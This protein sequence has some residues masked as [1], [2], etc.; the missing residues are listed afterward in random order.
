MNRPI[1]FY[2]PSCIALPKAIILIRSNCDY[3]ELDSNHC[4]DI[5]R[6]K[7]RRPEESIRFFR[8]SLFVHQLFKYSLTACETTLP[9]A[10]PAVSFI[11]WPTTCPIGLS[12]LIP[13]LT[14]SS[15]T[16]STESCLGK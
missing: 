7:K 1:L 5:C 10:L 15:L 11:T 3:E 4:L 14:I 6:L 9:S 2:S 13:R 8:A 16:S 12:L